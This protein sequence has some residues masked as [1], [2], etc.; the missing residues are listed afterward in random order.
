MTTKVVLPKPGMGTEEGTILKWFKAEGDPVKKGEAIAEIE[1]AKATQELEAPISGL[2][3]KI[4]VAQ[5]E[6]VPVNSEIAVIE[7]EHE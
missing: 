4:V 5:G 1:Y 3:A 6:T 2:L 7:N